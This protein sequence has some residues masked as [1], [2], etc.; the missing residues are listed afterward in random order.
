MEVT[1]TLRP[2]DRGTARLLREYGERLV[3]VRYRFDRERKKNLT[4]VEIVVDERDAT[5]AKGKWDPE[6][7]GWILSYPSARKLGLEGC[8]IQAIDPRYRSKHAG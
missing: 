1:K 4:T 7:R 3:C 2:G 6:V 8:I 5:Q